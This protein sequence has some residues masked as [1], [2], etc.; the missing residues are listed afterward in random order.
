MKVQSEQTVL[1]LA[2]AIELSARIV[3]EVSGTDIA[4][5]INGSVVGSSEMRQMVGSIITRELSTFT[6]SNKQA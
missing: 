6:K 1:G 2:T 4:D 3:A 5:T